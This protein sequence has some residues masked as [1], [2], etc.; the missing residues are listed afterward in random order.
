[1]YMVRDSYSFRDLPDSQLRDRMVYIYV[2]GFPS[3]VFRAKVVGACWKHGEL[4]ELICLHKGEFVNA[5]LE[6]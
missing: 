5:V 4:S 3:W 1:M 6:G 2:P